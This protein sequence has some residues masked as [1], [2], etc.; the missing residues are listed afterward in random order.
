MLKKRLILVELNEFNEELLEKVSRDFNL[1]NIKKFLCMQKSETISTEKKEHFGLD[2]WVQWVSIHTGCSH[3]VHEIDHLA[4]VRKLNYPQIWETIGQKGFSSGIWGAMNSSRNNAKNCS[5]F[6]PDPWTY[7]ERAF[8][9]EINDF[10]ALPRYFSKNYLSI[11][12]LKILPKILSILKFLV[13][14]INLFYLRKEVFYSFK[15]L[16]SRGLND[17]VLF[18]LFDLISA[19]VFVKYKKKLDP[20]LS[21]I[22]L[23]CLAHAQHKD[24]SKNKLNADIKLTIETVDKILG[25]I[26]E[27]LEDKEPIII[28][29]GLGQTNIDGTNYFIY[30]QN[31]P[32]LFLKDLQIQFKHL[33]Q[34]MTNESHVYFENNSDLQNAIRLLKNASI[35]EE[36]LFFVERDKNDKKKIFFQLNYFKSTD[37]NAKFMINK[38]SYKFFK[39]FSL[40]ARRTGAHTPYGK[41]FYK[42]FK[43]QKSLYNR[44]INHYILNYF[45]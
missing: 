38:K 32:D 5:F 36:P 25:I 27:V 6:L 17:T 35:N 1:K 29:N 31:D 16:L 10:L 19:K 18:S 14:E 28:L 8:P 20:N 39:Y 42:N 9:K 12:F 21:I 13:F 22:F 33:E 7:S 4:D 11:S 44:E 30:R 2:P 23:N 34:C 15:C 26:F 37:K 40:L 24:W 43:L 3:S 45:N 41:A